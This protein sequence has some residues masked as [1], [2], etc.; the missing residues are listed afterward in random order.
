MKY[1]FNWSLSKEEKGAVLSAML[2]HAFAGK[3]PEWQDFYLDEP[4]LRELSEAGMGVGP[5]GHSHE[6][7]SR[8]SPELQ[9]E[10]IDFSCAFIDRVG[11]S[12]QWGYCYPFGSKSSFSQSDPRDRGRGGLPLCLRRGGGRYSRPYG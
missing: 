4:A 8:L 1:L 3:P 12:R 7:T 9:K 2:D 10:E 5:H 6:V 11:G